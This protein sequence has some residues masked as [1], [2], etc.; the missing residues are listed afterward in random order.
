MSAVTVPLRSRMITGFVLKEVKRPTFDTKAVRTVISTQP[1]PSHAL[2]IARWIS[3][4]YACSTGEALRQFTP[5]KPTI[6]K[7]GQR[8]EEIPADTSQLELT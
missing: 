1:L 5:S 8:A 7:P 2:K 4:Y 3:D 6:R